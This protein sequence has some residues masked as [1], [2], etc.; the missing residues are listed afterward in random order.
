MASLL[1]LELSRDDLVEQIMAL[2]EEEEVEGKTDTIAILI[3][4]L[5]KMVPIDL[6]KIKF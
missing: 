3:E 1:D 2:I 4:F 6:E 5:R